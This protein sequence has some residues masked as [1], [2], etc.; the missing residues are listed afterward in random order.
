MWRNLSLDGNYD[1]PTNANFLYT[2]RTFYRD[3]TDLYIDG[4]NML[5][6]FF[7]YYKILENI[8]NFIQLLQLLYWFVY[9]FE[10]KKKLN[11]FIKH[12]LLYAI[13]T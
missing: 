4:V 11:G 6:M 9:Q 10:S 13:K 5:K 12:L 1:V 3:I 7:W 2:I 8:N